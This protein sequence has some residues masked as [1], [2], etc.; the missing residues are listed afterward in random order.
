MDGSDN[1]GSGVTDGSVNLFTRAPAWQTVALSITSGYET[2]KARNNAGTKQQKYETTRVR[3]S[4]S[5]KQREYDTAK[6]WKYESTRARNNKTTKN[7]GTCTKLR[8]N[9]RAKLR[10]NEMATHKGDAKQRNARL[11]NNKRRCETT[12]LRNYETRKSETTKGQYEKKRNF[13]QRM[14]AMA[15]SG[16]HNFAM[17]TCVVGQ[18]KDCF[19]FGHVNI[20]LCF[21][22]V[23]YN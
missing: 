19:H 9:K 5:T 10:N 15:L 17:T 23:V 20:E 13:K 8:N 21:V 18:L 1:R 2:K 12:I 14:C 22:L 6:V 4:E 3:N 11:R 16:L 7:E